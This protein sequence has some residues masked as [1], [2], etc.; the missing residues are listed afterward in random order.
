[1]ALCNPEVAFSLYD[2]DVLIATLPASNL[3]QRIV[4]AI[5]GKDIAKNL[6]EVGADT[7]IVRIEGFV[8]RPSAAKKTNREQYLFVNGRYFSSPYFRKAI[9]QAY[10]KLIAPDT[11]P[12][13]FLYLDDRSAA[14]RRECASAKDRD[15]VRRRT[16][17]LADFQRC[18]A[19][20]ARQ[21]GSRA[22][23]GFRDGQ[24]DRHSRIP[25]GCRFQDSRSGDQSGLQSVPG[26]E[27]GG[28]A[29]FSASDNRAPKHWENLYPVRED[30]ATE[31]GFP[32][33]R[34]KEY[35]SAEL[36]FIDGSDSGTVQQ[37]LELDAERPFSGVLPFGK[38]YCVA[39]LREGL[40]VVDL[41][42]AFE[43]VLF[44]RYRGLLGNNASVTQQLLFPEQVA[45]TR[46]EQAL[47]AESGGEIEAMGFDF[48]TER[49]GVSVFG[50]PAD[51]PDAQIA[52]TLRELLAELR[53]TGACTD[54][55]RHERMGG[56]TRAEGSPFAGRGSRRR[57]CRAVARGVVRMR[58][59]QLHAGRGFCAD[60]YNGRRDRRK[61]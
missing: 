3:R 16:G 40:A 49:D 33:Q 2:N 48:R 23:D 58:F 1:M 9:L 20:V 60:L 28:A 10:E 22:D 45:L 61:I 43:R 30:D 6:L 37:T 34:F 46:E 32:E 36:E 47:I 50:I 41:R 12:S 18:R 51:L 38:R 57:R 29:C 52:G 8:G 25:G 27:D 17:R 24:F 26:G 54:E 59:V 35:D 44:E 53:E 19:G 14:D 55:K 39:R 42:R 5:G 21:T 7:S 56:D 4:S 31:P 13:Y 15:Q 11:Q